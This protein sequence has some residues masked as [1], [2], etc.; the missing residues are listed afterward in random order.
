MLSL[1]RIVSYS[2]EAVD[3][4]ITKRQ[5][6]EVKPVCLNTAEAVDNVI[7]YIFIDDIVGFVSIPPKQS[8]M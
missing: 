2:A 8:T 6:V 5:L 3:N 1:C 4:V 7:F